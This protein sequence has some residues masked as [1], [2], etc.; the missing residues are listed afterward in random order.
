M[1]TRCR[2]NVRRA[3]ARGGGGCATAGRRRSRRWRSRSGHSRSRT[4]AA[5]APTGSTCAI[6]RTARWCGRRR[7]RP[8]GRRAATAGRCCCAS[9]VPATS[10]TAHRAAATRRCRPRS[11]RAHDDPP[12]LPSQGETTRARVRRRG[13]GAAR[14]DLAARAARSGIPRRAARHAHRGAHGRAA[15]RGCAST[16]C[17]PDQ[18]SGSGL[19]RRG[20]PDAR[21]AAHQEHGVRAA[22]A[23][24][25]VSVQR[26]WFR[27]RRRPVRDRVGEAC[28]ARPV[29]GG[30]PGALFPGPGDSPPQTEV[31]RRPTDPTAARGRRGRPA[32]RRVRRL[33]DQTPTRRGRAPEP[34]SWCRCR[35]R[36]KG[37]DGVIERADAEGA[38]RSGARAR[39]RGAGASSCASIRPPTTTSTRPGARGSRP[40]RSSTANCTCCRSPRCAIAACSSGRSA[41]SSCM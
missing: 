13:R 12:Y 41:T 38:R 16:A 30:N 10:T 1:V 8:S 21:L 37:S 4:A 32:T 9:G 22:A 28:R 29:G 35:T 33:G 24:R 31:P 15:S 18:I 5:I 19:A 20:R 11:G 34:A 25:C 17:T 36:T 2:R 6:R 23:R 40:A 14:T 39:R 27:P 7:R 26:P 3:R